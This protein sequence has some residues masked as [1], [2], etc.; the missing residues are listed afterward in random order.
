MTCLVQFQAR[1]APRATLQRRRGQLGL[2]ASG[3]R[4]HN[5]ADF[6]DMVELLVLR[7]RSL[8][9]S[10]PWRHLSECQCGACIVVSFCSDGVSNTCVRLSCICIHPVIFLSH[11][12]DLDRWRYCASNWI[13]YY[14]STSTCGES[15]RPSYETGLGRTHKNACLH[16]C[17]FACRLNNAIDMEAKLKPKILS[18]EQKWQIWCM[19]P[20]HLPPHLWIN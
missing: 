12:D 6:H 17:M 9:S 3:C 4:C 11:H 1:S 5:C 19:T 20:P 14:A 13:S 15:I 18:V 16:Q 8:R 7:R 10:H 2:H